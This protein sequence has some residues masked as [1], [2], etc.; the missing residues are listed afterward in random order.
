MLWVPRSTICARPPDPAKPSS[1]RLQLRELAINDVHAVFAISIEGGNSRQ[2]ATPGP[3]LRGAA[4]LGHTAGD[5]NRPTLIVHLT[6]GWDGGAVRL[7]R[8]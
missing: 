7:T 6:P 3:D 5:C 2:D 8:L 4:H 1:Q